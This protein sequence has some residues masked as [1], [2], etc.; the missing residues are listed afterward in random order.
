MWLDHSWFIDFFFPH[1]F[2]YS[3]EFNYTSDRWVLFCYA[4]L[5]LACCVSCVFIHLYPHLK[6]ILCFS[7]LCK[8]GK[9]CIVY[10]IPYWLAFLFNNK[11]D[12]WSAQYFL[13]WMYYELFSCSDVGHLPCFQSFWCFKQYCVA[14]IIHT[15][16]A[17][18]GVF[19]TYQE[20][21]LLGH[22]MW[23]RHFT[24]F[25]PVVLQSGCTNLHT[26]VREYLSVSSWHS[27]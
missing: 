15:P 2:S 5:Q 6:E 18:A 27:V 13:I 3:V 23:V 7:F 16:C 14:I 21:D 26:W 19:I 12:S 17:H 9:Y 25:C 20:V 10:C 11:G 22:W 4:E 24:I 8:W 1:C